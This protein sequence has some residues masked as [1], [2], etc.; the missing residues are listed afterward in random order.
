MISFYIHFSVISRESI[1]IA[2][3]TSAPPPS[4]TRSP[5]SA[6]VRKQDEN[7][8]EE[9]LHGSQELDIDGDGIVPDTD[10]VE[11]KDDYGDEELK[12]IDNTEVT[13]DEAEQDHDPVDLIDREEAGD[14]NVDITTE[15]KKG[16]PL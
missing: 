3:G 14:D 2:P 9:D 15:G 8:T 7:D 4:A 6:T 10:D 1:G 11:L 16:K 12:D 13:N 5:S